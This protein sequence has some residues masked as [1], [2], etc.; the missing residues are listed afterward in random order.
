MFKEMCD[1]RLQVTNDAWNPPYPSSDELA[2]MLDKNTTKSLAKTNGKFRWWDSYY[3]EAASPDF[4]TMQEALLFKVME[5]RGYLW[6]GQTFTKQE[7]R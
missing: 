7:G 3:D 4:D 6:N 1:A 5:Q 2:E